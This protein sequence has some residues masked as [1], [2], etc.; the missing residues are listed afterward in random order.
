MLKSPLR[1]CRCGRQ[2]RFWSLTGLC[3][4]DLPRIK[5]S[6]PLSLWA[7]N[8]RQVPR[9]GALTSS[10]GPVGDNGHR[11]DPFDPRANPRPHN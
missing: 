8:S 5:A 10:M 4:P 3:G 11:Q 2:C 6:R 7:L 9:G 1:A